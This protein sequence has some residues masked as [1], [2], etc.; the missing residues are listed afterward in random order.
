M[1][2]NN[3]LLSPQPSINLTPLRM[4]EILDQAIRLYRHNFLT[5]VGILAVVQVPI[6]MITMLSLAGLNS[7]QTGTSA[8]PTTEQITALWASMAASFGGIFGSALLHFILVQG[9]AGAAL[10]RAIAAS[11]TGQ[12]TSVTNAY[13]QTTDLWK[14]LLG[15]LAIAG[16]VSLGLIIWTVVPCVGWVTGI[17]AAYFFGGSVIPLVAPVVVLEKHNAINSVRRA[18]DLARSRIWWMMGFSIIVYLFSM[19]IVSGP[20]LVVQSVMQYT[21]LSDPSVTS[22][23]LETIISSL[24]GLVSSLLFLP[25]QATAY[26]LAYL[27][28]RVRYEGLDLAL[29]VAQASGPL[30]DL[31]PV[32]A[33]SAPAPRQDLIIGAD[34][35]KFA[36]VSLAGIALYLLFVGGMIAVFAIIGAAGPNIFNSMP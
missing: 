35:S 9:V 3:T 31:Q 7:V 2:Q 15:A 25:L 34:W 10:T 4:G 28:L 29:A 22:V 11:Y 21:A 6:T 36:L 1:V 14:R 23:V 19:L 33:S 8:N 16:L 32:T 24:V 20:S 5:F 30:Q 17:G 27:D 26:I 18:W 12:P 13:R